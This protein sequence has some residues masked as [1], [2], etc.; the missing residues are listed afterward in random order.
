MFK[1]CTQPPILVTSI[2]S[3]EIYTQY[4]H[5]RIYTHTYINHFGI[6]SETP[7]LTV[8]EVLDLTDG[9]AS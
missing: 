8:L 5:T 3:F 1:F 4:T 9:F 6:S 2:L 7:T